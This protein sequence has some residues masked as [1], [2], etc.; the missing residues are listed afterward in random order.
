M[1]FGLLLYQWWMLALVRLI[2][3]AV[4]THVNR[5]SGASPLRRPGAMRLWIAIGL[6]QMT[7]AR[8]AWFA[9]FKKTVIWRGIEYQI[10]PRRSIR[11]VN[12]MPYTQVR[13][14]ETGQSID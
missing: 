2:G 5:I 9:T 1:I 12:Y 4:A 13:L 6:S 11:R 7:Y 3:S 14:R 8:A 10:G